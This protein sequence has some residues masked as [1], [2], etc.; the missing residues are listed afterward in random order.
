MS[1]RPLLLL[2]NDDGIDSVGLHVLARAM[3][4]HGDVLIVAPDAEYSGSGAALGA[5]HLIRPEV[6][7]VA[8]E[9]IDRAYSVSGPPALCAL[10]AALGAFGRAPDLVVAGINPGAN[11]GRAVYHSGTV[12]AVLTA[13]GRFI[14]GVAVSQEVAEIAV[15]GQGGEVGL[16][17]QR[18]QDAADV[19]DVIVGGLFRGGLPSDPVVINLNVPNR[20]IA[21]MTG[22][23]LSTV[24]TQPPR[25]MSSARLEPR[26]GH[27]GSFHVEMSWGDPVAMAAHTDS[28]AI[29]A[30]KISVSFLSRLDHVEST[31]HTGVEL[32]LDELFL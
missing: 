12:G 26:G 13:R 5:L 23:Q 32:T 9:G 2:T 8:I 10:F 3:R 4:R 15:E 14:N 17:T 19:A 20:P 16:A 25:T 6:H 29:E 22:W 11:V 31:V 28:G 27:I 30:G 21:E 24:A 18:W 7:E 1:L